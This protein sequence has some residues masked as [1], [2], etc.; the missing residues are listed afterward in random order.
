MKPRSLLFS[1][2]LIV[3]VCAVVWVCYMCLHGW[4]VYNKEYDNA[5][6]GQR[7]SMMVWTALCK[8]GANMIVTEATNCYKER[9]AIERS[10]RVIAAEHTAKHLLAHTNPLGFLPYCGTGTSCAFLLQW[11]IATVLQHW[12]YVLLI[13]GGL[14]F[15]TLYVYIRVVRF[16]ETQL[17]MGSFQ[18]PQPQLQYMTITTPTIEEVQ[19]PRLTR[20]PALPTYNTKDAVRR[21]PSPVYSSM[22]NTQFSAW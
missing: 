15:C 6:Y 21:R 16:R 17:K 13:M 7:N 12:F 2:W 14:A 3:Y 11:G 8:N 1:L 19:T 5:A 4:A 9:Q 10:P 20:S 22:S 18:Q